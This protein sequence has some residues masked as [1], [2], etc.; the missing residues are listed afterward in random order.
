MR[1]DTKSYDVAVIGGGPVGC[2]TALAFARRGASVLLLEANPKASARLA[3]EWLHPGALDVLNA[4]DVDL[5][6]SA[7][8]DTGRGFVVY[9]D[10]GSR[11]IVLPY[12]GGS[13]G[14]GIHHEH[15]VRTLRE[16]VGRFGNIEYLEHARATRIVGQNLTFTT[17]TGMTRTIFSDL[18]VGAAGRASVAHAALG[19][20]GSGGTY[21][22]MAGLLLEDTEV[23]FEGYGHVCLGGLGP[24]LI[25][26]LNA[27]HVRVCIDVPLSARISRDKEAVLYE[28]Y[29]YAL[30]E[31]LREPFRRALLSGDVS[32]ATNQTRARVN[33]GR[34]GLVLVGDAVGHH[35]P[36]TAL[37]MSLG[38]QDAL[39]L[40]S[41]PSF[42]AFR[43]ERMNK[44]RVPEMLA[45][46][47]YEVF[48]DTHDEVIETRRAIYDLWR[49]S[50]VE[51]SRT[52]RFLACQETSPLLFGSS[53]VKAMAIAARKLVTHGAS[54]S[55]W[56]HVRS[57]TNELGSRI[58]WLLAGSF[59]LT[60]P[61]PS[62]E[63]PR[64]TEERYAGAVRAAQVRAD[65]VELPSAAGHA[66]RT[67]QDRW[68][69][70][71]A[72]ERGIRSLEALQD[73][74]GSWEGEV[75]WC[76]LLAAQYVIAWWIMGRPIAEERKRRLLLHFER[77]RHSDGLWGM[78]EVSE[79]SLFVTTLVYVAARILGLDASASMLQP[80]R[81]FFQREGG[82]SRIPSWGKLWLALASVYGWEGVNP[83]P[84]EL[85]ALPSRLPVHPSRYHC[86]TRLVFLS[87]AALYG[88]R[89]QSPRSPLVE[90]LREELYPGG[91]ENVDFASA[92]G[93]LRREDLF[94]EPSRVLK[95][96]YDVLR[97]L[98]RAQTDGGRKRALE[99]IRASI[100]WELRA[101]SHMALS[102]VSGLLDVLALWSGDPADLD[103]NKA[104]SRFDGWL[105]E[106]DRDGT[107]VTGV[108]SATWD[109][110]LATRA[111][112]A[113]SRH[114]DVHES[115]ARADA[116]L[117]AQQIRETLRGSDDNFRIDPKGGFPFAFSCHGWPVSEC[118]AEA[119]LARLEAGVRGGPSDDEIAMAAAFILRT[120][121][122]DGSFGSYEPRR[123]PIS[124]DWLNPAEIFGD[125]MTEI[126]NAESTASCVAAL[127]RVARERPSIAARPE[128]CGLDEAIE[129]GSR[130]LRRLQLPEGC[131]HGSHGVHFIYGTMFGI[132]GLL[133]AGVPPTDPAIRKA[134]SWVKTHQRPDGSWGERHSV[135]PKSYVE[136]EEGQVVQTAWALS[137]LLEAQDP[138]WDAIE[139]AARF[140]ARA[141]LGSGEWPRQAPHGAFF[142]TAVLEYSLYRFY[143]PLWAL[144]QFESRRK[145]RSR[146]L[147]E[148]KR[149]HVAAE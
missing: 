148:A 131:W 76:P 140:L 89:L 69:P 81:A 72:L 95:A 36:L 122:A 32:W 110:S 20:A 3:G 5:T 6:P 16:N 77:S 4:L 41:A 106:D 35:H 61:R 130:F 34:P 49:E 118:T 121:A 97:V 109:T 31:S 30:P 47:L 53:F 129:R 46:A 48:A 93:A 33:F 100:R 37:G 96:G 99:K 86:Q 50:P 58:R 7:P 29:A 87:W 27:K 39:T 119:T 28:S 94:G 92:R 114:V 21:S 11:P 8:Y 132:R 124:L 85:W 25:Y 52:M 19:I 91:Y 9:P 40:S 115:L 142:H 67:G 134:T 111:L 43:R 98:D 56:S 128:L 103:A 70:T 45:V 102:P 133:S 17:K 38:F 73:D 63:L 59:H 14:L 136:H 22:R 44:S 62:K 117:S 101:T 144:A 146:L 145:E 2:V 64:A 79:P 74:D 26:R 108:R 107:R 78:S 66:A 116:F 60:E 105:W 13:A 83:V 82:V 75:V 51:R 24:I 54:T 143:F 135:H 42:A 113:A 123:L 71:R 12:G 139:R 138:D 112:V 68:D 15:L 126:G 127:A 141:Q 149:G 90:A 18:I 57:I 88:E 65:V 1:K 104:V 84:P 55:Q 125:A 80:A 120:Q 147:D 137:A 10:D 23:P